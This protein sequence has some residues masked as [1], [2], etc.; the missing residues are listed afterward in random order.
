VK[1]LR[2][3]ARTAA[4]A[5]LAT[6]ACAA[7]GVRAQ[8]QSLDALPSYRP[9][10]R[11]S[12]T[13]R[14]WGHGS[15]KS[16]F[17]GRV[18]KAWADGFAKYQPDVKLENHMYGT[19]SAIGA[20]A[21]GEADV[22]LL[23]E[24]ISPAAARM[25]ARAKHYAP[26]QVDVATGSLDTAYFDYAHVVFVN[27]ENP[28]A[29]LTLQQLDAVF[30]AEHRRGPRNVRS[31][32]ELGLTG[33]WAARRIQPYGWKDLDFSLFVQG[34]VLRG[35]HR[36]NGDLRDFSH[37]RRADGTTYEAGQQILDALAGDRYGIAI[38]SLHYTNPLV[39]PIAL[40]AAPGA[41]YYA[42]TKENL[43]SQAYPLTRIVP[44]FVD[45][46]PGRPLD[47]K[48]R[49]F[50]RY[51]LSREGQR[52]IV[53]QT[54]YL[55]LSGPAVRAQLAKLDPP[56]AGIVISPN[57]RGASAPADV[58]GENAPP[59]TLRVWSSAAMSG[60]VARWAAGYRRAHPDVRIAAT[61]SGSDLAVAGLYTGRADVAL[62][63]REPTASEVQAFEWVYRAKPMRVEIM[64]GSL[65]VHEKSPALAVLVNRDNPLA[66]LTLAQLAAIF[67]YE[68]P[69]GAANVRRWGQLGLGLPWAARPIELYGPDITSGT[70]LFFRHAVLNDSRKLE[71]DRM[72]ELP[73]A[74][75]A[76][77]LAR[78][79]FGIA[80]APLV[81]A[82]PRV[83]AIAVAPDP[84]GAFVAPTPLNV[85]SRRYPLTRSVVALVRRLPDRPL[86][87]AVAEFLRY[88]LSDDG[89]ADVARE[90]G[91]LPLPGA[92]VRSQIAAVDETGV[93][94][95]TKIYAQQ[96]VDE[97]AARAPELLVVAM[98]VTPPKSSANVIVASNIGRI[99]NASDADDLRV[100]ETGAPRLEPA[101]DGTRFRIEL[102]LR[103]TSGA[104]LGALDLTLPSKPHADRA[105]LQRKAEQI[106][107]GL[108]RRILNAANL[109][110]PY[111]ID[112]AMAT[113]TR[114]Q[115]LVD[116]AMD[117]HPELLS[118]AL[119]VTLP[120]TGENVI[121]GSSFGRIGKRADADDMKVID[122]GKTEPGIFAGGKRYG[123][124][125]ALRDAR[126]TT[127]GALSVAYP[128]RAGDETAL[129]ARAERLRDELRQQFDSADQLAELD[130]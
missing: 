83:K 117:R 115:R 50:L 51:V 70:G 65:G 119:H 48:V 1:L 45:R 11:V 81:F 54:G 127:I 68:H 36:W 120:A 100:I 41:P 93:R 7:A 19:A 18:F 94:I 107:D 27:Q 20:L 105:L 118:L 130:P 40:A 78:D 46:A 3:A 98:R 110:D 129:L 111:P 23:G 30:G 16:D 112:P 89:Q 55:Q 77:A 43:I 17:M 57:A 96:L 91:Y 114:A 44:A 21:L 33:A 123:L 72:R 58:Y 82:A 28:L 47:P 10:A 39:K 14:I 63:G 24:E 113:K 8:A 53:E 9:D 84:A 37:L 75:I 66:K 76:G 104:T 69:R 116:R 86:A 31:W 61:A 122:S 87:P 97:I 99:G 124:E 73:A 108:S 90:G 12:G 85:A 106:R 126:G 109:F 13:I 38:S 62:L 88:V 67:G 22:A 15:F 79:R 102:P 74:E 92:V 80:V 59:G 49:E 64:S 26:L 34:A 25:F 5:A 35:S 2:L 121:L 95:P 60:V 56:S 32:G 71:W 4:I 103:D 6:C 101:A 29:R 125:L 42:A 128:Y 52:A